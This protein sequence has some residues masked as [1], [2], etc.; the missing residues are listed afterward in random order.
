MIKTALLEKLAHGQRARGSRQVEFSMEFS[1]LLDEISPEQTLTDAK[2]DLE[3]PRE[4]IVVPLPLPSKLDVSLAD[5]VMFAVP[6]RVEA[7]VAPEPVVEQT[8][9]TIDDRIDDTAGLPID[10]IVAAAAPKVSRFAASG[11]DDDMLP[12]EAPRRRLRR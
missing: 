5:L 9:D 6:Q 3:P 12:V 8:Q 10:V 11:I 7:A 4:A 1:D 2:L